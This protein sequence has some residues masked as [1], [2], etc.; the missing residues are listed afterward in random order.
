MRSMLEVMSDRDILQFNRETVDELKKGNEPK[1]ILNALKRLHPEEYE[2]LTAALS[3]DS[4]LRQ[5]RE[6]ALAF[7]EKNLQEKTVIHGANALLECND[8]VTLLAQ[9]E[10]QA[11]EAPDS[12]VLSGQAWNFPTGLGTD[13][14]DLRN[15]MHGFFRGIEGIPDDWKERIQAKIATIKEEI[16]A[17]MASYQPQS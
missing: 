13:W 15:M 17:E 12:S 14:N 3:L 7:M 5:T 4:T 9:L 8:L 6:A 1:D 10:K 11:N 16:T 2:Q